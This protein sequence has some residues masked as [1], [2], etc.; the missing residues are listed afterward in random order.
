MKC[1]YCSCDIELTWA[2]YWKAPFGRYTCPQCDNRFRMKNS[3]RYFATLVG[4]AFIFGGIPFGLARL[5]GAS[6]LQAWAAY[7]VCAFLF[8]LPID[9]RIDATWRGTMPTLSMVLIELTRLKDRVQKLE[10]ERDHTE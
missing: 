6:D 3:F 7:F 9:K 5:L 10:A 1:P 2:R 8:I 4:L